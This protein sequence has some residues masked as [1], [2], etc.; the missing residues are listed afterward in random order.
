[1]SQLVA[2]LAQAPRHGITLG[3]YCNAVAYNGELSIHMQCHLNSLQATDIVA[4]NTVTTITQSC[5]ELRIL[6]SLM[7][8]EY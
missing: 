3:L 8:F 1:M 4:P 7:K 6:K 5:L 2:F